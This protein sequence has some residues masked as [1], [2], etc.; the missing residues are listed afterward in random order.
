MGVDTSVIQNEITNL[1][2]V[3]EG[4]QAY[5]ASVADRVQAAVDEAVA[6]NDAADLSALQSL[7]TEIRAESDAISTAITANTPA[8]DE[9]GV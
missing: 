9:G 3:K 6:A 5:V 7:S 2:T 4:V 8:A 1:R